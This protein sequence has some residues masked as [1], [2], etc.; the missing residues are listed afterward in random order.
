MRIG[1]EYKIA[2]LSQNLYNAEDL[3][4]DEGKESWELVT[5]V[6]MTGIIYKGEDHED[7]YY[8]FF[9]HKIES[10]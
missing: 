7:D 10:R 9:K 3:L 5:V 4:N 8:A 6:H 1:W 2:P